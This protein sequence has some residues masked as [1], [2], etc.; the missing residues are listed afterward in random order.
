MGPGRARS[1][2]G[3]SACAACELAAPLYLLGLPVHCLLI[4]WQWQ[5]ELVEQLDSSL[6]QSQTPV[7]DV[8]WRKRPTRHKVTCVSSWSRDTWRTWS[9][10]AAW[11]ARP[12]RL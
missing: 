8:S 3:R 9:A 7:S 4:Y 6:G 10:P 5:H 11:L 2:A 1:L 12:A